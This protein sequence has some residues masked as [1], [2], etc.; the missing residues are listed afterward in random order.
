M[1]SVLI[2]ALSFFSTTS[3]QLLS[4]PICFLERDPA[5]LGLLLDSTQPNRIFREADWMSAYD[6]LKNKRHLI[7]SLGAKKQNCWPEMRPLGILWPTHGYVLEWIGENSES[8]LPSENVCWVG[9]IFK[10]GVP[11]TAWYAEPM[12]FGRTQQKE[13][14]PFLWLDKLWLLMLEICGKLGK[15]CYLG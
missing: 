5:N 13:R 9:S 10:Y 3:S 12:V 4:Y 7:C 14:N 2:T 8:K 15:S 11:P 6:I 1:P